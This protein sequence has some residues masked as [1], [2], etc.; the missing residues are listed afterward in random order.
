MESNQLK[1]LL[2]QHGV[3]WSQ[4]QEA[5]DSEDRIVAIITNQGNYWLK[6]AAPARGFFR[7]HALNLFSRILRLP[8]LKA[9][10][11][12]GGNAAIQTGVNRI[13]A[14]DSCDVLVPQIIIHDDSW[15]LTRDVGTSIIDELK[16][17]ATHQARRQQ[18]FKACL[19]S[20]KEVHLKNQYLSQAFIRNM[21]LHNEQSMQVAFIDF[22]DDPLT[23]MGLPE[24]QAR[25]VLLFV[26]STARFFVEDDIFFNNSIQ[27]FL[28]G[29]DATMITALRST[30]S[31]LQWITR[32]P[33]QK[34]FGH[35]YQ[36]LKT[37]ILALKKL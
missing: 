12:P 28:S 8:L 21:L 23:V 14:L 26:N 33:L 31:R 27:Q 36:K 10:P 3:T 5:M 18:L 37:G 4:W 32:I 30:A 11:Q 15:L 16:S 22:E 6:K 20:I 7:Y 13:K 9:V 1:A 17:T 19:S 24:A 29:H 34:L 2:T 35:D 25:D